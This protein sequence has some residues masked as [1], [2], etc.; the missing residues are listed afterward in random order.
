MT[1]EEFWHKDKRLYE[2]YRKAYYG[3]IQ[4]VAWLNGLYIDLALNNFGANMGKKKGEKPETYPNQPKELFKEQTP[5]TPQNLESE[6][7]DLQKNQ[8]D[9]I[10]SLLKNKK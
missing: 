10:R 3:R 4:E 1:T 9:F 5:F 8:N 6:Y 2:V 7:R